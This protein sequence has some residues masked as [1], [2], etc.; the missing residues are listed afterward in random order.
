MFDEDE[1]DELLAQAQRCLDEQEASRAILLFDE[2]LA[3][4]PDDAEAYDDRGLAYLQLGKYRSAARDFQRAIKIAEDAGEEPDALS[5]THLAETLRDMGKFDEALAAV[6]QALEI[7]DD[8]PDARY[9][10]GWL[11]F[12]CGQYREAADDLA[13]FVEDGEIGDIGEVGDM[14]NVCEKINRGDLDEEQIARELRRNGFSDDTARNGNFAVEE[15][16]C[17]Y[18]HCI[19]LQPARGVEADDCCPMTGFA[20]P[21]GEKQAE[22]CDQEFD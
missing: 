6:A 5:H 15:L 3:L 13:F 10:R 17:P 22:I 21:G 7:E 16:R 20:C 12:H 9:L 4:H 18:A 19:R 8:L 2:Y 14:L 1:E 11:F